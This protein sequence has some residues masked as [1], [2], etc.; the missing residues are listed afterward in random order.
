MLAHCARTVLQSPSFNRSGLSRRIHGRLVCHQS[1]PHLWKKLWKSPFFMNP[2]EEVLARIET[3]VNRYTFHQWFRPTSFVAEDRTSITV[4][5]PALVFQDWLPKHYS[6]VI[7]EA[8][9]ETNRPNLTIRYV[10]DS[11]SENQPAAAGA[12][13]LDEP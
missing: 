7:S 13:T 12:Q 1:F 9:A 8:L 6:G 10:S 11:A 5:V 4:R 2:W 3:K